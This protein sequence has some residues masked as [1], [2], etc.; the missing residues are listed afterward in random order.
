MMITKI[1]S[2]L[3]IGGFLVGFFLLMLVVSFFYTPFAVNEMRSTERFLPPGQPYLLGTDNFGRD[4]FSRVMKGTQTAFLVGTISVLI[5]MVMGVSLG[6][7][8]GYFGGWTDRIIAQLNATLQAFP[9]VLL[10]LMIVAAFG[11]GTFNTIVALSITAIP[12]FIRITRSGF[13]QLKEYS[14][15]EAAETIGLSPLQI[16]IR[17]ILPNVVPALLVAASTGFAG[18]LLA[19]AGLSYLGLGVQPPEPS[20]GRMLNEAQGYLLRAPWYSLA[21]GFVL[22]LAVLGFNLLSD[23]IRDLLDPKN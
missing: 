17:H 1:S 2:S 13:L 5:G 6:A 10:A 16:M 22:L 19:E 12:G 4:I 20:W 18:A 7:L 15:V 8:S 9:G 14:F 23:G 21:P 11:P 3:V